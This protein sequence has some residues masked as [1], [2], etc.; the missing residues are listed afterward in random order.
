MDWTHKSTSLNQQHQRERRMRIKVIF[1]RAAVGCITSGRYFQRWAGAAVQLPETFCSWRA[2]R[3]RANT[4]SPE[5]VCNNGN[6]RYSSLPNVNDSQRNSRAW[7]IILR[8]AIAAR[9]EGSDS[10]WKTSSVEKNQLTLKLLMILTFNSSVTET[11]QFPKYSSF[12]KLQKTV[13]K[14]R[15]L[16]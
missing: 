1:L 13:T 9:L 5:C 6:K 8:N 4:A 10:T 2:D 3:L 16:A 12:H 11:Q 7:H 14:L 15:S